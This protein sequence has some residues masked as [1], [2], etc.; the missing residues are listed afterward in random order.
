MRKFFSSMIALSLAITAAA[1]PVPPGG[2][3]GGPF[4][5]MPVDQ[6]PGGTLEKPTISARGAQMMVDAIVSAATAKRE[7]VSISIVD[8]GGNLLLF[9]RM[10]G[11]DLGS[12]QAAMNKAFSALKLQSPTGVFMDMLNKNPALAQGFISAGFTIL[13]GGEP[14][15][16]HGQ[17]VGAIAV[18]G[19]GRD[20]YYIDIGQ[21]AFR[22]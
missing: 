21:K 5:R 11:A 1:Q 15:R 19:G 6:A 8:A 14:I 3:A 7:A 10:D 18:S 17:V 12:A 2:A 16:A 4:A 22:P 9:K 13:G 20:Q